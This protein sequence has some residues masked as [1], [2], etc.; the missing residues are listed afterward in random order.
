MLGRNAGAGPSRTHGGGLR[1]PRQLD[2]DGFDDPLGL[3]VA[4][5]SEQAR[6]LLEGRGARAPS[7]SR[8]RRPS[9][10]N[11]RSS[12]FLVC[13]RPVSTSPAVTMKKEI[14]QRLMAV[15]VW[16]RSR[17]GA[18]RT[19]ASSPRCWRRSR[20]RESAPQNGSSPSRRTSWRGC[21]ARRPVR[22]GRA[23]RLGGRP[24]GGV[25]AGQARD[26]RR[27]DT[28]AADKLLEEAAAGIDELRL[29]GDGGRAAGSP[30]LPRGGRG[31]AC[32]PRSRRGLRSAPEQ[33]LTSCSGRTS[34]MSRSNR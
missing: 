19:A 11:A 9:S 20:R 25:G 32:S 16:T 34:R 22:P 1:A 26:A 2:R 13:P 31:G 5:L 18:G 6:R 4:S 29:D 7:S 28:A 3:A 15:Y 17:G 24:A 10:Q 33:V 12:L 8:N 21:L 14:V 27:G 23:L 30:L